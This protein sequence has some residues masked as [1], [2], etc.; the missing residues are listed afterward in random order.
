MV[1]SGSNSTSGTKPIGAKK[2]V[3]TGEFTVT[4]D[5]KG[6]ILIPSR[7]KSE[8]NTD[9]V[10]ITKS[11]DS[12][13][14][15]QVLKKETFENLANTLLNSPLSAFSKEN[16]LLQMRLIA[17]AQEVPFDKAGRI[18]VHSS[19]RDFAS[20]ELKS[21]VV[22]LG[23]LDRLEIWNKDEYKTSCSL[24]DDPELIEEAVSQLFSQK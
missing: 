1:E 6:R 9:N 12:R 22:V 21:E 2:E 19:L 17:P 15:L 16:K 11:S 13:K 5:E 7:L 3:L 10:V 24:S 20:I 4:V 14:C 8:L 18:I 23:M